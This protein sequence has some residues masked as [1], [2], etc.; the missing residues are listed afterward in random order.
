MTLDLDAI[1]RQL[2]GEDWH[3]AQRRKND[4]T[5]RALLIG[6]YAGV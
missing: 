2:L 5:F 3:T 1:T 6:Y 4:L